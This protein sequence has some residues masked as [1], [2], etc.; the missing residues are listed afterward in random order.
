[1]FF[2][3][4]QYINLA[5]FNIIDILS[6]RIQMK[7]I[8]IVYHTTSYFQICGIAYPKG[9]RG[10]CGASTHVPWGDP[11]ADDCS[12]ACPR[13]VLPSTAPGCTVRRWVNT[14]TIVLNFIAKT[15]V[16]IWANQI[17]KFLT[18]CAGK[19]QPIHR[20]VLLNSGIN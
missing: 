8:K 15:R 4:S 7:I 17:Y 16:N 13:R 19:T 14:K 6:N 1:M 5:P 20:T 12:S 10:T 2:P 3:E 9:L 18:G 11:Q